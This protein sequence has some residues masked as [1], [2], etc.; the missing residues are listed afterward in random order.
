MDTLVRENKA[1]FIIL[2]LLSHDS[3]TGY[4]LRQIAERMIGNFWTDLSYGQ[5]YPTLRTLEKQGLVSKTAEVEEGERIRKIY[6]ITPEGVGELRKWLIEP[7]DTEILKLDILLKLTFGAK[8]GIEYSI[9]NVEEFKQRNE[10]AIER[11]DAIE[12]SLHNTLHENEDHA[13]FLLTLHYGQ[14]VTRAQIQWA[15]KALETLHATS[16]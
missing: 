4:D 12:R 16:K 9:K 13:F 3:L 15:N 5:I 8:V 7:A 6:S 14:Y 10:A 1:K 11:Y 2:G